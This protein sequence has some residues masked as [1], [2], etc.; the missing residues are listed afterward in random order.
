MAPKSQKCE[1]HGTPGG[2]IGTFNN[3]GRV[4]YRHCQLIQ[5]GNAIA[6]KTRV[7]MEEEKEDKKVENG[8]SGS[9]VVYKIEDVPPW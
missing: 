7:D 1:N 6:L 8:G 2:P 3:T 9:D 5:N 4:H